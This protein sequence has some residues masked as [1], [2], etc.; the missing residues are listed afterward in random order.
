MRKFRA[1]ARLFR[2]TENA[3]I[4]ELYTHVLNQPLFIEPGLG[5]QLRGAYMSGAIVYRSERSPARESRLGGLELSGARAS[6]PWPGPS[7]DGPQSYEEIRAACDA[8]MDDASV[9]AVVLRIDSPGGL[10]AG[11]FDLTDHIYSRRGEKPIH[12]VIDDIAF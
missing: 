3:V 4:A 11:L 1:L 5:E 10:A 6:R 12:A 8:L 9:D 7:G 2:R